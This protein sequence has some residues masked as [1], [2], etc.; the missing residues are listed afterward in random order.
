MWTLPGRRRLFIGLL[1]LPALLA[2]GFFVYRSIPPRPNLVL[3]C[4]DTVRYDTFWLT[5]SAGLEDSLTPWTRLAIR[6]R[7]AQAVSPWTI[8]SIAS[9]MTGLLPPRHRAG[10][11]QG[12]VHDLSRQV[13]TSLPP[14]LPTLAGL[15][16]TEG[17]RTANF[18]S[19]PWMTIGEFGLSRGFREEVPSPEEEIVEDAFRWLLRREPRQPFFLNLHFMAAHEAYRQPVSV[20]R[21]NLKR[22]D[23]A[24]AAAARASAPSQLSP[25][26]DGESPRYLEYVRSVSHLRGRLAKI[27]AALMEAELLSNTIVFVFSDHGEEFRDHLEQER[28]DAADPR[29]IYG[30]GHGHTLYQEQLRIP[31]LAWVPGQPGADFEAPVSH[32]DV[33]PTLLS[34]LGASHLAPQWDGIDLSSH[35][36]GEADGPVDR[37]LFATGIAYGPPASAVTLGS[38]KLIRSSGKD[39]LFD[40]DTDPGELSPIH[41]SH[42]Q[43]VLELARLLD[44]IEAPGEGLLPPSITPEELERLRSLGYVSN[45]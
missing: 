36:A 21:Q 44:Q 43:R 40:L 7:N 35:V 23:S 3:I 33:A 34:W 14:E 32:I 10:L 1:L 39:R 20:I 24:L 6:F 28:Q 12:P 15:L 27:L 38:W 5:E 13:P 30:R 19:H 22:L 17:Y 42:P 4:L 9:V 18:S 37:P 41:D 2:V 45:R 26:P 29:G 16:E 8:P 31:M 25:E 11:F